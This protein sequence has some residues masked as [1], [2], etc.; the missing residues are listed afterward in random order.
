M[1]AERII[2]Y[3]SMGISHLMLMVE[4][5][6]LFH[7]RHPATPIAVLVTPYP[8][9][10]LITA[11]L[12]HIS[13]AAPSSLSFHYLPN[14]SLSSPPSSPTTPS[15]SFDR[16]RLNNPNLRQTLELIMSK[17][18]VV[19]KAFVIDFFNTAAHEV[20]S[21]FGIPTFYY[22]PISACA[23][24]ATLYLPT[25][26]RTTVNSLKDM[27]I[28]VYI[29]GLPPV[30]S[31]H[32]PMSM[33][34]RTTELYYNFLDLAAQMPKAEGVI[35][36]TF[37][38]LEARTVKAISDGL[39]VP[40]GRTPPLFCIGPLIAESGD[41]DAGSDSDERHGCLSWLDSQP[42]R[43]VL[44]LCFGSMGVFSARQL[45]EMAIG[46]ER[47][48][49]RFLWVVRLPPSPPPPQEVVD[50][51][52]GKLACG[53]HEA[54]VISTLEEILPAGFVE[55]TEGRGL[56]WDSWVPQVEVLSHESVGGF[57]T[58]CGWNSVLEAVWHGLPLIAWPI[59][60]E[61][62][63]NKVFLVEEAKLALPLEAAEEEEE[64]F[65]GAEELARRVRELMGSKSGK[66]IRERVMRMR[67]GAKAA[68]REGGSS[69]AALD[70]LAQLWK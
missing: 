8:N 35:I 43:S 40:G 16:A 12:D 36:N 46:L 47:S 21:H 60:A 31:D 17:D 1:A 11:Y 7:R 26:H 29:P 50:K 64:G 19:V 34:D 66:A 70:R 2:M 27:D 30:P 45:R 15:L 67:D 68:I 54:Q 24:A 52:G 13:S 49:H 44:F 65:V 28:H 58:H 6:K 53:D 22:F 59:F 33:L 48:G 61:Q 63:L 41:K 9:S 14:P 42:S 20:A 5:A 38:M 62:N 25:V 4:L 37:T 18:S 57:V 69:R 51:S 3:P 10:S 56:V 55:R 39:C 32:M 23:L